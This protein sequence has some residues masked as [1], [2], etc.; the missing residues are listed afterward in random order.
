LKQLKWDLIGCGDISRKRVT[1]ALRDLAN[2][3]FVAVNS[4]QYDQAESF[5]REYGA[6]KWFRTWGKSCF[7][8]ASLRMKPRCFSILSI[9]S[10][11]AAVCVPLVLH[12]VELPEGPTKPA[13]EFHHFPGRLHA[14]VWRNWESVSLERM[15]AVLQTTP[16]NVCEIGE[17][18]G[19]PPYK[20]PSPDMQTRGY[21]S[22]IRRNWHLLPYDQ[23]LTL[24]GWDTGRLAF[25]LR[26]D[27]FLWVKLGRLK[28]V[29]LPLIYEPPDRA[30][31]A[32]C[33]EI[34]TSLSSYFGRDLSS[35]KE[36]RFGFVG[37]LTDVDPDYTP[38]RDNSSGDDR[39]RFLYSYFGVF[40]DPLLNSE[41]DPYP[42]GLLQRL[43][44]QGVN[45]VWLHTVLR[46]LA[47][48]TLFPE[49]S[50][51]CESRIGNLSKLV[52]RAG[53]YGIKIYLYMNEPRAMPESFFEGREHLKGGKEGD[54]YALCTSVPEVRQWLRDSLSYVFSHVPGLGGVFTIT[55]SENFT[56]CWSH[57]REASGCPRC[58]K[59]TP[60]EVIA[61]VNRT[62]FE[63]V[64]SASSEAS[65]IAWD[66]GWRDEWAEQV[67]DNL[68]DEVYLMSVSE[69]SKP[70]ERGGIKSTVGEYSISSVG[71][72]PRAIRH[73][74]HAKQR[75]LRTIAKMQ[76]NC[77]WE[78]SA[79][80]YL[81][82][83]N[84][85]EQHCRNL[86]AT[87]IDGMM[88]SWTVGGY[89]SP[90]LELVS[91]FGHDT[92]PSGT[93][94]PDIALVRY[95]T[96]AAPDALKAWEKFS[97]AF[98]QYPFHINFV[99]RGPAQYGPSNL[100][101]PEPTGYSATMIG[102][103]YDD[104]DGWRAVYPAEVLAAQFEKLAAGWED[105][106]DAFRRGLEKETTPDHRKNILDDL[107]IAEAAQIH[108]KSAAAQ[109]QFINARNALLAGIDDPEK[110]TRLCNEI[111]ALVTDEI[112][113]ARRLYTLTCEDSRIGYEA[114]NHYYYL[115][116]DLVEKVI[117]C[118]YI[119]NTWLPEK[120]S[121]ARR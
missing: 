96:Q 59:R 67:I 93:V 58:S 57:G 111:R 87:D 112:N 85:I 37:T 16:A 1:P 18:M 70:I 108:F 73:W 13:L 91:Q 24:L 32:R 5:A 3:D 43:S 83:M 113:N 25:T 65:V 106:L 92:P 71:P 120:E 101:F 100:L 12:A 119:L 6:R 45:G 78:L 104:V 17:S 116:L 21:I 115:P 51:D 9:L 42:D 107:R 98:S 56:N 4:T 50:R 114:S 66:W 97:T 69:W 35:P 47:P 62:V 19:L 34:K 26:E 81:P 82:V 89:P 22:I 39:I 105:G 23:L 8:K 54:H 36:P 7:K 2:C 102:F 76:V 53:R 40:G 74:A 95:G 60:A 63:G 118:E 68:P 15:A 121:K 75:G 10:V 84:T 61:E 41:L 14:F 99:Y 103:P 72:G 27:D 33:E 49:D 80:P 109:V 77:S 110:R 79:L 88:L 55:A 52:E 46:H 38:F 48:S 90:N 28:P 117:N 20:K 29:C 94:L 30:S 64:R 86:A 11:L 44:E 31:R